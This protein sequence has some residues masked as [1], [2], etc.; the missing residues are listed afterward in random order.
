MERWRLRSGESIQKII[1]TAKEDLKKFP[2][3]KTY[4]P[5]DPAQAGQTAKMYHAKLFR[6]EGLSV[7]FIK[8]GTTKSKLTRFEPFANA[9]ENQI[10]RYVKGDWND[11][12]FSELEGF[13]GIS[14]TK[15]DDVVDSTSDAFNTLATTKEYKV[16]SASMIG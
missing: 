4:L 1:D 6:D 2:N 14:R 7:K 15:K 10:V 3:T 13:D 16:L 11:D 9:A 5:Q 12:F 8:V